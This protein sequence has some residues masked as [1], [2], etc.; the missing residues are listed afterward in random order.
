MSKPD[1]I[2][3]KLAF[4]EVFNRV[5][6]IKAMTLWAKTHRT[7]FYS[8]YS[9]LT[10]QPVVQTNITATVKVESEDQLRATLEHALHRIV[11]AR[12]G[13]QAS[14]I[15][16]ARANRNAVGEP[17]PQTIDG[18]PPSPAAAQC[19]PD[20][21]VPL[22][23]VTRSVGPSVPGLYAGVALDSADDGLSTTERFILWNGHGRPP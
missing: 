15:I 10:N 11:D 14:V 23:S 7:L 1:L 2:E 3:P 20:N 12:A 4:A 9:K 5:G 6:G 8:L 13:E 22:R 16:D 21:V 18:S 17:Q 19:A